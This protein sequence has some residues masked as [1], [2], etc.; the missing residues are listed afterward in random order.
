MA[1]GFITLNNV[2]FLSNMARSA[3]A[4]FDVKPGAKVTAV[5]CFAL[6]NVASDLAGCFS[7]DS[8]MLTVINSKC[9]YQNC[10]CAILLPIVMWRC[11]GQLV[12]S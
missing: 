10:D 5:N 4:A 9:F 12:I 1:A 8:A 6:A 11:G 2:S 3:A 7:V